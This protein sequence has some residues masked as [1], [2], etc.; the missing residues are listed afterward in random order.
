[1][2]APRLLPLHFCVPYALNIAKGRGIPA[3]IVMSLWCVFTGFARDSYEVPFP[4]RGL[5][6]YNKARL[7]FERYGP[8][9]NEACLIPGL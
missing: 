7:L 5:S 1:M 6:Q 9:P 4:V 8:T 2:L 3:I